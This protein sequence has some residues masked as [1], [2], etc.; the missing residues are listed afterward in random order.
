MRSRLGF[1][2]VMALGVVVMLAG[3]AFGDTIIYNNLTPNNLMGVATRPDVL[4]FEIDSTGSIC[5][6][7][8]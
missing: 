4:S 1:L 2:C 5:N 8:M 6:V 3:P 7:L